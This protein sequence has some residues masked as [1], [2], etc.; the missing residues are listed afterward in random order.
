ME[1]TL[2]FASLP[3]L[4]HG[5]AFQECPQSYGD[6]VVKVASF[7]TAPLTLLWNEIG[8]LA[9]SP[10]DKPIP[11]SAIGHWDGSVTELRDKYNWKILPFLADYNCTY[12]GQGIC[13]LRLG[14]KV[15]YIISDHIL[16]KIIATKYKAFVRGDSLRVWRERVSTDGL[17][18]GAKSTKFRQQ[19]LFAIGESRFP[20]FFPSVD[21]IS[22]KW[23]ERLKLLT[24]E[25]GSFD[26]MRECERATLAALGESIFKRDIENPDEPNP[27]SLNFK[28][29]AQITRFLDAY[30]SLF[31]LVAEQIPS[32]LANIPLVGDA[33]YSWKYWGKSAA[34]ERDKATLQGILRPIF[35]NLLR[36]PENIDKNSDFYRLLENFEIDIYNPN[37][38]QILD[39]SLGFIQAAFE[40]ASK[41][42]G[43]SLYALAAHPEVQ[44]KLRAQL[45]D[46][47]MESP[48]ESLEDLKKVPLLF[49]VVEECLRL[50]PPFPF[51]LRDIEKP[52]EFKE[53]AVNKGETFIISPLFIHHNKN[54]WGEDCDSFNPERFTD[55]M[56]TDGWQLKN[57]QY[58]PFA[59]G[60]H[61]CPGRF[62]A[63]QEIVLQIYKLLMNFDLKLAP[64]APPVELDFCLT[65]QA[66]NPIHLLFKELEKEE[67]VYL[68]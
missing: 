55:E 38:D 47:F 12:G 35:E 54:I 51:Q 30:H 26:L 28:N 34:F 31:S 46:A 68:G 27:F 4:N 23:V 18:E 59:W 13:K 9:G 56:L 43:W 29:E 24:K 67:M 49:K 63:K 33:L 2:P 42:L 60:A 22:A 6:G 15:F 11:P 10:E 8:K 17:G 45:Q 39:Y 1:N 7:V 44:E 66:K 53:F 37:Y 64:Q 48:P 16:A 61:R 5:A 25:E 52:E 40:T 65:L 36:D 3:S 19:A 21:R 14:T 57:P 50:Y 41:A 58:F 32:P 20:H 62:K